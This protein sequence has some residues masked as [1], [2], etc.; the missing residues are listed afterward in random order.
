MS[1]IPALSMLLVLGS[2]NVN[3]TA[4]RGT[5]AWIEKKA[6]AIAAGVVI[7]VVA[8]GV[9]YAYWTNTGSGTGEATTG[10]N[11]SLVINQTSTI[12]G[13]APGEP[14]QVLSGTFDNPNDSPVFVTEVT[15]TV[16]G[17][18]QDGCDATDYTIGGS[19][20]V[21]AQVPSGDGVGSWS[22]PTIQFN[23]KP[24]AN[25]DACKN[26]VVAIAYAAN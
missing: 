11:D 17:T 13:L 14:A 2:T 7:L 18:D 1:L 22:G 9:A 23:N 16:T 26:A 21:N 8:A 19:A 4:N 12:T 10:T 24:G 3:H 6:V 25:Q 5:Y 15:A 20:P